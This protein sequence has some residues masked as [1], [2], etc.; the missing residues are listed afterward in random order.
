MFAFSAT[1]HD[2]TSCLFVHTSGQDFQGRPTRKLQ[3]T[4][5]ASSN[6]RQEKESPQSDWE[7][8]TSQR[9]WSQTGLREE[10]PPTTPN[11]YARVKQP[12]MIGDPKSRSIETTSQSNMAPHRLTAELDSLF[13]LR[14][15]LQR[16]DV[17][18]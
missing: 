7:A 1:A 14:K 11:A 12:E 16:F 3:G 10:W 8:A 5:G 2:R 17:S 15:L 6:H 9:K 4:T 18:M 13:S